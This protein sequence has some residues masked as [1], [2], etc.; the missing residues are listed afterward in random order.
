MPEEV[1]DMC[2]RTLLRILTFG[3]LGKEKNTEEELMRKD[4]EK[5]IIKKEA[6]K[7]KIAEKL[8]SKLSKGKK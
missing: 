6:M 5:E 8:K 4:I 2:F 7:K 3:M 1:K